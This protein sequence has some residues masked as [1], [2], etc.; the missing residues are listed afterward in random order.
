MLHRPTSPARAEAYR[1]KLR[2]ELAATIVARIRLLDTTQVRAAAML[3]I[4]QPRLNALLN[5]RAEMFSLDALVELAR[6]TGLNVTIK[7]TRPY[8]ARS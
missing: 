2:R 3:G 4:T 7:A 5:G 6:R 8:S 1:M